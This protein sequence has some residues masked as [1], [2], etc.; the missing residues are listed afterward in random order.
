MEKLLLSR[1]E[2]YS[3]C[4]NMSGNIDFE[5]VIAPIMLEAQTVDIKPKLGDRL[6]SDVLTAI[7]NAKKPQTLELV[8][9]CDKKWSLKAELD[10]ETWQTVY[11]RDQY[12]GEENCRQVSSLCKVTYEVERTADNKYEYD[13]AI[14]DCTANPFTDLLEG[15]SYTDT[16]G[17]FRTFSGL[18]KA[19]AYYT[20]ARFLRNPNGFLSA[21]GFVQADSDYSSFV[22]FRDKER[23]VIDMKAVAD[24]Y[25]D[26]CLGYVRNK[27]NDYL[28]ENKPKQSGFISVIG[29]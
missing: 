21:T 10:M 14:V 23:T 28:C 13:R 5:R 4:R 6:L 19:A 3:L 15:G 26:E 22:E 25:M 29:D 9:I 27:M 24:T 2:F 1:E 17:N 8:T 7:E 11:V 16:C 12:L 20:Y 18:K